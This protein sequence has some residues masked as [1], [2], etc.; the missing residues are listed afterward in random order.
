MHAKPQQ[1]LNSK[2]NCIPQLFK[3]T[4]CCGETQFISTHEDGLVLFT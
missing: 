2:T 4:T 1:I 3:L